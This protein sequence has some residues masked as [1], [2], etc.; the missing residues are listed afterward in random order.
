MNKPKKLLVPKFKFYNN[1]NKIH[2]AI[3]EDSQDYIEIIK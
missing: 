2:H 3:L 1:K